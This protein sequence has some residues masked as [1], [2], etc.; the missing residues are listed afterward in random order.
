MQNSKVLQRLHQ[1]CIIIIKCSYCFSVW[2]GIP[3]QLSKKLYTLFNKCFRKI[4]GICWSITITNLFSK[5][6]LG[7]MSLLLERGYRSGPV[8]SKTY[9]TDLFL[10]TI[11]RWTPQGQEA[12]QIHGEELSK[13]VEIEG[14]TCGMSSKMTFDLDK[15]HS[16]VSALCVGRASRG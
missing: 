1:N 9:K 3:L 11:I 4:L 6:S 8:M 10:M 5:T 7:P 15:W 16:T 12:Q 2:C 13:E 14:Q